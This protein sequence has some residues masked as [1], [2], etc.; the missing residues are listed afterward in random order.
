[1]R[2]EKVPPLDKTTLGLNHAK[3]SAVSLKEDKSL[4]S[5]PYQD[6]EDELL[7]DVE[8]HKNAVL[9]QKKRIIRENRIERAKKTRDYDSSKLFSAVEFLSGPSNGN[10]T[11]NGSESD[12]K[13]VE[14]IKSLKKSIKNDFNF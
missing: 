8:K 14:K 12:E 3:I 7:T 10:G 9:R 11:P 6:F 13:F 5:E 1:M 2:N 4:K